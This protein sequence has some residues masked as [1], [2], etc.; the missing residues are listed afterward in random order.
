LNNANSKT[1]T[2]AAD[3]F[4]LHLAVGNL[5]TLAEKQDDLKAYL[6]VFLQAAIDIMAG[7]GGKLWVVHETTLREVLRSGKSDQYLPVQADGSADEAGLLETIQTDFRPAVTHMAPRDGHGD[8]LIGVFIPIVVENAVFSVFMVLLKRKDN[9][10]YRE[11]IAFL[12]ALGLTVKNFLGQKQM[13]KVKDRL[14]EISKLFDINRAIF[15]SIDD[16]EIAYY[17]AN[18]VPSVIKADRCIAALEKNGKIEITA[19]SGQDVIERKSEAVGNL[20]D[21]LSHIFRGGEPATL[22]R[23][24]VESVTDPGFLQAIKKYFA[25]SPFDTLYAHPIRDDHTGYGVI[26]IETSRQEGF[27]ANEIALFNF[28]VRQV[29]L[30]FKNIKRYRDIP[31]VGLWNRVHERYLKIKTM[32]RAAV[33]F[34]VFVVL[35]VFAV[36]FLFRV[37]KNINADCKILPAYRYFARPRVDG[38]LKKFLVREGQLVGTGRTVAQL[39]DERINKLLREARA[40]QESAKANMTKYFGIGNISD[41]EIEKM[42]YEAIALEIQL[43]EQS[44]AETQIIAGKKGVVLTSDIELN[45]KI[46]KPVQKGEELLE[47]GDIEN[48]VLEVEVPESKIR[49]IDKEG[50]VQFLLNSFPEKKFNTKVDRIRTKAEVRATGN[51]FIVEGDLKE[52]S[53]ILKPGMKGKAK[54]SAGKVPVWKYLFGDMIDYFRIKLF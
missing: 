29:M 46:D 7:E 27:P 12:S 48:L 36:F 50:E 3:G 5:L 13:P 40:R 52:N 26:S 54:V 39:D 28:I 23:E 51:M 17:L 37:E 15:S 21:L 49:S 2:P 16:M 32:P 25:D 44:L 9:L 38:Y 11:E 47:L 45:E 43:L 41:Y 30:S 24:S 8:A 31:F 4:R 1:N 10:V 35:C 19:V 34:R 42:R 6:G 14:E 18:A 33:G 20:E 22:T 53:S